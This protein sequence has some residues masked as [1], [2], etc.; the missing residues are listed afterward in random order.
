M[1]QQKTYATVVTPQENWCV[2]ITYVFC[3]ILHYFALFGGLGLNKSSSISM[4]G[5]VILAYFS[6]TEF[7]LFDESADRVSRFLGVAI[8]CFGTVTVCL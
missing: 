1:G 8:I 6:G 2:A 4:S 7:P 3:T 5:V